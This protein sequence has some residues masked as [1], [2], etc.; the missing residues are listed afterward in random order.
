[1]I[2]LS[3]L[4]T[5]LI[6]PYFS[7]IVLSQFLISICV[8]V[9]LSLFTST[10]SSTAILILDFLLHITLLF[11]SCSIFKGTNFAIF[12]KLLFWTAQYNVV[13][14]HLCMEFVMVLHIS[15][16]LLFVF[17]VCIFFRIYE[18]SINQYNFDV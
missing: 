9:F 4:H 5:A 10:T 1:M 17:G 11:L 6:T 15:R 18:R 12:S 7:D 3:F 14:F 16:Y 8:F 13:T 2:C